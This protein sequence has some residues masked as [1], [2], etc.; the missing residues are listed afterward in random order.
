LR[1][2]ILLHDPASLPRGEEP[3]I[4]SGQEA[5]QALRAD[6]AM[7]QERPSGNCM[8]I[9]TYCS[10]LPNPHGK[11]VLVRSLS[12]HGTSNCIVLLI[13]NV[14]LEM[15]GQLRLWELYPREG[16]AVPIM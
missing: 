12:A 8:P 5:R 1:L 10:P 9:S 7:A 15:S 6:V 14:V 4:P 16:T 2:N 13:L 3:P 11:T